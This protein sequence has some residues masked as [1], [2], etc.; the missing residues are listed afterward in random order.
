MMPTLQSDPDNV[1]KFDYDWWSKYYYSIGDE[2]R[3]QKDYV[4]KNLDRV[5]IYPGELE[6]AFNRCVGGVARGWSLLSGGGA[7]GGVSQCGIHPLAFCPL[8]GLWT[9][10]RRSLCSAARGHAV[11]TSRPIMPLA[12]SREGSRS[13][14]YQTTG[15][16]SRTESCA[17][18]LPPT[19]STS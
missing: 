18:F 12:T 3:T 4:A 15:A 5:V 6:D 10:P 9:L 17:T 13:T 8:P 1:D 19:P 14:L 7:R 2:R 16:Q 11:Q